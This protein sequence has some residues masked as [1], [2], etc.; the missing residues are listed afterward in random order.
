[1]CVRVCVLYF[2][3]ARPLELKG[4]ITMPPGVSAISRYRPFWKSAPYDITGRRVHLDV[5]A[6][7]DQS[8]GL[9][10]GP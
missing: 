7:I 10:S 1:M 8:T 3:L 6:G 5:L 2:P 4:P 9:P